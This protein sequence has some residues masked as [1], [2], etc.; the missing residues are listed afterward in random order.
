MTHPLQTALVF[1]C[2]TM[3]GS[4]L[5]VCIYRLPRNKSLVRP[6]SHCPNCQQPVRMWHNLPVVSYLLLR[7]KCPSCGAPISARY[8]LV[9]VLTGALLAALF[10]LY[11]P[12]AIFLEYAILVLFLIPISF[13]DLDYQ[14]ILNKLT[15]PG[16]VVGLALSI[17]FNPLTP[18][19]ALL[20]LV[21]G[22]GFLWSVAL[23]GKALFKKDS[24]GSGDIKL[25]AMIGTYLGPQVV[26]ALFFAFFLSVPVLVVGLSSGRLRIG[27]TLPFGPFI[28][29]GAITMI[30]LGERLIT[31]YLNYL[32]A[33]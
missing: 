30:C 4:F 17:L 3:L 13:I 12:T 24:M 9:E 2:G 23:L 16:M 6:G 22:G 33:I 19:H 8:P 10:Y 28:S 31:L 29:L 26:L 7:G 25:A 11:G 21:L 27:S 5:N 18:W 15:V 14:L 1:A 20:G 32:E